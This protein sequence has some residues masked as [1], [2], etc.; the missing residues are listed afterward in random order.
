[1]PRTPVATAAIRK[2]EAV[3]SGVRATGTEEKNTNR[4]T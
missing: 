2:S 1:V 3:I 4:C